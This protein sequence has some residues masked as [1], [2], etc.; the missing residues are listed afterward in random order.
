MPGVVTVLTFSC[1]CVDQSTGPD[2]TDAAHNSLL[3]LLPSHSTEEGNLGT[4]WSAA[5][6][7][8]MASIHTDYRS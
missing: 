8:H 2:C 5:A 1:L 4:E 7:A 6:G 3:G